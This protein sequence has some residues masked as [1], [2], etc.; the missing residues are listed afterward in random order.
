[1]MWFSDPD[2]GFYQGFWVLG[3]FCGQIRT[4]IWLPDR[5]VN[6]KPIIMG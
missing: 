6:P 2:M 1:M 4:S 3:W 5:W